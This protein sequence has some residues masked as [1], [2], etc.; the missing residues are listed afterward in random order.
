MHFKVVDGTQNMSI[1][2]EKSLNET[3]FQAATHYTGPAVVYAG[4]GSGKTKVIC[5]RISWLIQEKH[6]PPYAILA[7]TF[8]NK[9]A[10][11]MK[12]RIQKEIGEEKA[13]KLMVSTFHSFCARFLRIYADKLGFD[14]S[15]SIY[16]DN[17][18]KA[19][20]KNVL[21]QL[22]ISDQLLSVAT[23]KSKIDN[24]K[25]QGM[26]PKDYEKTLG[27][28]SA[29]N[30]FTNSFFRMRASPFLVQK[31]Y[32]EYQ[33]KLKAQN[34]LDFND[35][36]LAMTQLLKLYP[37]VLESLQSRFKYFLI[38]EFQDT[39]PIQFELISLLASKT[40]NLFIVGDDDQSIYSWRGA[41]PSFILNFTKL[42][43]DAKLFKL[44]QNYRSSKNIIQAAANVIQHNR[45]RA[46]KTIFTQNEPGSRIS[47]YAAFD[48]PTEAH[49]IVNSIYTRLDDD[50]NFSNFCILYR[51]NAQS[52]LLEDALRKRMIPYII[53]GSVRFYE[54]A[55]IKVL[56]SYLKILINPKDDQSFLKII[57]TPRRGLGD[58]AIDK[59]TEIATSQD[60]SLVHVATE[61][62]Y[63]GIE[64][65]HIRALSK[66]KKLIMML[67]EWK[68]FAQE[69]SK[70]SLLLQRMI[71]DLRFEDYV[72][73]TYP[74][75]FD[76]RLLNVLELKN[77][78]VEFE[79]QY[80]NDAENAG[81]DI[82][83]ITSYEIISKFIEQAMLMVEPTHHNVQA[84]H[85]NAVTLMTVHSAK[86][87]E[88]PQVYIA[89]LEEGTF[90]HQN[91]LNS[92]EEIEEERRLMYV[93]MTR[94]KQRLT[95]TYSRRHRYKEFLPTQ[96]SRFIDEIPTE[97]I[98]AY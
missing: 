18:Q 36:L 52:R 43:E 4:A 70:A 28:N 85:S 60:L 76:E 69:S 5:S 87:L 62:V 80:L 81:E 22:E 91:S 95:L 59:L 53:Y 20:L 21:K 50:K 6:V 90:P 66:L 89:G 54:R 8:T 2:S 74:E 47:V 14:N 86:G 30:G 96:K 45:G 73:S 63:G 64:T 75:D 51:T 67:Q 15:F 10:K 72:R 84:G 78:L 27:Q 88:F 48:P 93:A 98:S 12:E 56:L 42:F 7:V 82:S 46:P 39:N 57:N 17:D 34:A 24:I 9:A 23:V 3:Q 19:L 79:N 25:N 40:K 31:V 13:R 68:S 32:A 58:S 29:S 49:F 33:K 35:L 26:T 92:P 11:E 38:D 83:K 41:D 94:A 77:G 97:F 44:E 16:D 65:E 61:V 71:S 37:E 1:L 55:E